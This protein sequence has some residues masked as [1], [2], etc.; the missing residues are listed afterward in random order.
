MNSRRWLSILQS[1][2]NFR[3]IPISAV[4]RCFFE[5][6]CESIVRRMNENG[7]KTF[8]GLDRMTDRFFFERVFLMKA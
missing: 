1:I 7:G 6:S 8:F 5:S 3:R 2:F 4:Y